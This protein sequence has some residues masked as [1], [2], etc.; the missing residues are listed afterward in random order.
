MGFLV[1]VGVFWY[2]SGRDVVIWRMSG[3]PLLLLP[4]PLV[5]VI[6]PENAGRDAST[7]SVATLGPLNEHEK[8]GA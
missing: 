7:L 5:F 8:K 4:H 3:S 1:Y 2:V 6:Q